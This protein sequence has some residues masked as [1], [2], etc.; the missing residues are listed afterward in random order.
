MVRP[1]GR[2]LAYSWKN[3]HGQCSVCW[4]REDIDEAS[5]TPETKQILYS[6]LEDDTI[7][8]VIH[9]KSS[10]YND[11]GVYHRAPEDCYPA[12]WSEDRELDHVTVNEKP[13][14]G[15][16]AD[17]LFKL[18]TDVVNEAE[19]NKDENYDGYDDRD[20]DD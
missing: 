8:T 11:P 10:G 20:D 2:A 9:F 7:E 3:I 19:L 18:H 5:L 15:P 6:L 13:I 1:F 12:D 17:E 4:T 14:E 16:A